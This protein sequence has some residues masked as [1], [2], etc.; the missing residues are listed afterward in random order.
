MNQEKITV[1]IVED[2]EDIREAWQ[3]LI[4]GSAGFECV[5]VYAD[6]EEALEKR[7]KP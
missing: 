7:P 1:S 5:H 4:S 3:V 2:I 6:A